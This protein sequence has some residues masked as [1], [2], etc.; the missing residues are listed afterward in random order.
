M[1]RLGGRGTKVEEEKN[2]QKNT[3]NT[4]VITVLIQDV[5]L[6]EYSSLEWT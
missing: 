5:K 6:L 4:R 3:Q 2:T 1:W